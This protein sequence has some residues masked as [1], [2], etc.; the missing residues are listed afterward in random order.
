MSQRYEY[1]IGLRVHHPSIDPLAISRELKMRPRISWRA[2][3]PRTTPT[4]T[5]LPGRRTGTYWSKAI[6]PHGT[7]VPTGKVAEEE[8]RKLVKRLRPHGR[9][10]RGLQRTGG[11]VEIWLSSYSTRNYSFIFMP[12]LMQSI[13]NIGCTLIVD[14]YPYRQ[15]WA[16]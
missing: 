8:L 10:V 16:A 2:G 15:K 6:N 5:A 7:K 11:T 14:V 13:Q 3:E 1:S 4:G 9:F 12:E